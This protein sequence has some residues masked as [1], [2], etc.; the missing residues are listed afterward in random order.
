MTRYPVHY[1]HQIWEQTADLMPRLDGKRV[2]VVGNSGFFGSWFEDYLRYARKWRGIIVRA[3]GGSRA[4]GLDV[5]RVT[6]YPESLRYADYMVN[7]AGDSAGGDLGVHMEGPSRLRLFGGTNLLQMSSGA[8]RPPKESETAFCYG[9]AKWAGDMSLT[10]GGCRSQIVRPFAVVGPGMPL[11]KSFAISSFIRKAL[12]GEAL[13]VSTPP[14]TRSFCHITD[15]VAQS[16]CVMLAGDGQPYEV[17]SDDAVTLDVA[18]RAVSSNVVLTES[19]FASNAA[20]SV[21][22]PDLARLRAAFPDLTLGYSS[23]AAIEDTVASFRA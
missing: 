22:V 11:D 21:Y 17:G 1:H 9:T 3:D 23:L 12:A 6:T 16:L 19:Q 4:T 15:L 13:E 8:A 14:V 20:S 18:A 10:G 7:C 2:F 5:L